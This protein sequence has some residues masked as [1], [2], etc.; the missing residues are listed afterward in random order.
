MRD[1]TLLASASVPWIAVLGAAV[2]T[3]AASIAAAFIARM[4]PAA[5]PGANAEV[6]TFLPQ[7]NARPRPQLPPRPAFINRRTEMERAVSKIRAGG[8]VLTIEGEIGVGKSAVASELVHRLHA[9]ADRFNLLEHAFVWLDA[10][11]GCPS[12]IDICRHLNLSNDH[13]SLSAIADS[14]KLDALR[15]HLADSKTVLLLD[16]LS[17]GRDAESAAVRELLRT[18]PS[19]SLVIASV[20][21]PAALQA[22]RVPLENLSLRHV[23]EMIRQQVDDLGLDRKGAFDDAFAERVH[24]AV[25]GNPFMIAWF[26]RALV[27]NPEPL[28]ARLTALEGGEGP[29]ELFARVW[30]DLG[31]AS[32][33]VL[34]ACAFLSGHAIV[35]Q[36]QVA[37]DMPA[38]A[39]LSELREL[40]SRG[41]VATTNGD[42]HAN[43]HACARGLQRYVLAQ[44]PDATLAA[45][46][47]RLS[48]HYVLHFE[49]SWEDAA[50]AIAHTDAIRT[51]LEQL[52][53]REDDRELQRLFHATF[54]IF[55]TL[56]LFDDRI[57]YGGLAYQSAVRAGNDRDASLASS[58]L[59]STHAI[60]G[61]FAQARE[62]LALGLIAAESSGSVGEA[63]RQMRET[64]FLSYRAGEPQHALTAIDGAEDLAREAGDLNNLVDILGLRMSAN[65][66]LQEIGAS[67]EAAARYLS[68]CEEIPWRRAKSNP[69]RHLAEIAIHR[70]QSEE[71]RQLLERARTI[72]VE[73]RDT[74]AMARITM[75][76]ARLLLFSR[77]PV[78]AT[79]TASRAASAASGL[80]LHAEATESRA[81]HRAA[82]RAIAFPPLFLR[83]SRQRPVRLTNAPVGGD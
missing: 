69:L 66:Y 22:P 37:C 15:L 76:E 50:W 71:A 19:G 56:G 29:E 25:G 63:A 38:Q 48:A 35:E 51:V 6:A 26:L 77:H 1:L 39:V 12:L 57:T 30:S 24:A 7:S 55:M 60:R 18:V 81:L 47:A 79:R 78:A 52:F 64:G 45:F 65:L 32:R 9:N 16:N 13:P 27:G 5:L 3:A 34:A 72:A 59:S 61:E 67:E 49:D 28:E 4:R 2:I 83:Y 36:L 80:G 31:E 75:T 46:T 74:R 68:L 43:A 58:V 8:S 73:Y 14:E 23:R 82:C 53:R 20:N 62:A 10:R 40:T 17:L 41:L 70:G 21:R 42:D 33:T 44:V 11:D 54:D